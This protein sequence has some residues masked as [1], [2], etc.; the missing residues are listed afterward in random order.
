[1][2]YPKRVKEGGC[3]Y[4]GYSM[5]ID[6]VGGDYTT[7]I[8]IYSGGCGVN[9]IAVIPSK[10]GLGDVFKLEHVQGTAGSTVIATLADSMPNMG[11]GIPINLD[12]FCVEKIYAGNSLK[13]TYSNT[14]LT[15]LT[16]F[17]I[18]ERGR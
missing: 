12:F 18:V 16:A 8:A 1:M 7:F 17:I 9:S 5:N 6:S 4:R 3:Y 13:L 2:G 10:A 14:A 15:S 11:A